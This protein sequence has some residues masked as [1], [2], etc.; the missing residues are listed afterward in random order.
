MGA[1]DFDFMRMYDNIPEIS[2]LSWI[3]RC[4]RFDLLNT[5]HT[6]RIEGLGLNDENKNIALI[7]DSLDIQYMAHLKISKT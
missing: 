5:Y 4:K 3:A 2:Q 7:S 1:V 6:F